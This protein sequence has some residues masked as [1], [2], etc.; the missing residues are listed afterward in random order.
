MYQCIT[1]LPV[2]E[3]TDH[4]MVSN[5]CRPWTLETPEVYKCVAGLLGVRNL[6][7]VGESG[8]HVMSLLPITGHNSRLRATTKKFLINRKM[9]SITLPDPGIEPEPLMVPTRQF[10][11]IFLIW[12]NHP[13]ISP[14]L[15]EARGSVGLLLTKNHPVPT[16]AF[17]TGASCPWAAAIA[18]FLRGEYHPLT[19]PALGEARGSVRLLLTKNHPVPSPAL[20]RSSGNLLRCPQLRMAAIA[21]HQMIRLLPVIEQKYHLMVNNHRYPWTPKTPEALQV[22]CQPFED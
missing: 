12:E 6:R 8:S 22:R 4:L 21:Y 20:S 11:L 10:L 1:K 7:D 3:Q 16:P 5:H 19:S 2:N 18:F 13:M 14:A 15:G 17:R 9:P